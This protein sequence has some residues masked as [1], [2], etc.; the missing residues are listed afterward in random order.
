[1]SIALFIVF[2]FMFIAWGNLS[3]NHFSKK[4]LLFQLSNCRL[5]DIPLYFIFLSPVTL[6]QPLYLNFH[7]NCLIHLLVLNITIYIS[8][9]TLR[10]LAFI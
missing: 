2:A 5:S 3:G 9:R 6:L 1:M 10:F 7:L 8:L 4:L